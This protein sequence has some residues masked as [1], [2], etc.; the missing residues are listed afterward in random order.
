MFKNVIGLTGQLVCLYISFH[1][2]RAYQAQ[3]GNLPIWLISIVV[4]YLTVMSLILF[5][6]DEK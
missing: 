3:D 2:G 5:S 6:A 1:F 4:F